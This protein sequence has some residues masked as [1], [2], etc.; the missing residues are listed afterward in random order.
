MQRT[1]LVSC[2]WHRV[3]SRENRTCRGT[4]EASTSD[5]PLFA[6]LETTW[7]R[8]YLEAR[9]RVIAVHGRRRD[10]TNQ[11]GLT[12]AGCWVNASWNLSIDMYGASITKAMP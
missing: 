3:E 6:K 2:S 7:K 4:S 10:E 11:V 1:I 8:E 12:E 9:Q 5:M